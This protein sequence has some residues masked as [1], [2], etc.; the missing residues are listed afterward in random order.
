MFSTVNRLNNKTKGSVHHSFLH[1]EGQ[2]QRCLEGIRMM[3]LHTAGTVVGREQ[4]QLEDMIFCKHGL[5]NRGH[6][7]ICNDGA[8]K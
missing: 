3:A 1:C 2:D 5:I 6:K 8:Q 7:N 4:D